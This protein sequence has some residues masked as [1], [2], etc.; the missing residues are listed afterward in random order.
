MAYHEIKETPSSRLTSIQP[1]N[2]TLQRE[3]MRLKCQES[4][5]LGLVDRSNVECRKS[6]TRAV[7]FSGPE[8][9]H[10]MHTAGIP[11]IREKQ[12]VIWRRRCDGRL[13]DEVI[14]DLAAIATTTI[15]QHGIPKRNWRR[16]FPT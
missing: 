10:C 12:R 5:I 8:R 3:F 16:L 7:A 11:E 2:L 9:R 6:L 15:A 4:R 14:L 1:H 13:H